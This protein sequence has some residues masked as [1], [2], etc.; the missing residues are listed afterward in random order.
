MYK[1]NIRRKKLKYKPHANIA[2]AIAI[3]IATA[4]ITYTTNT[5][6]LTMLAIIL[7]KDICNMVYDYVYQDIFLDGVLFSKYK[8][9][10]LLEPNDTDK[11]LNHDEDN[12]EYTYAHDWQ[13]SREHNNYTKLII[14]QNNIFPMMAKLGHLS[15]LKY[16]ITAKKTPRDKIIFCNNIVFRISCQYGSLNII[17]YLKEELDMTEKEI[18]MTHNHGFRMACRN[19]HI[20][21]VKY[22]IDAWDMKQICTYD[23]YY[24]I[25]KD[26]NVGAG[27]I[28]R[29]N[30]DIINFFRNK[31]GM[32]DFH[33]IWVLINFACRN[34]SDELLKHLYDEW[35]VD[36]ELFNT[37][38]MHDIKSII[39]KNNS[40]KV[41][42]FISEKWRYAIKMD[43]S[44]HDDLYG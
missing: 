33:Y 34:D 23:Y 36:A 29:V 3:T 44:Y 31:Y 41:A 6:M 35:N 26:A 27:E 42:K 32:P 39:R 2:I 21:T 5:V 20:D 14:H 10:S 19:N 18:T 7:P 1:N 37:K 40:T 28:E 15:V 13:N 4:I 12:T 8:Y 43:C 30:F 17:K 22:I 25:D 24:D 9:V 11:F 38:D 16:L